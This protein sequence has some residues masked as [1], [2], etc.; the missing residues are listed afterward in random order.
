MYVYYSFSDSFPLYKILSIVPICSLLIS[1]FSVIFTLD[2][3]IGLSPSSLT[4]LLCE[5][6]VKPIYWFGWGGGTVF[7]N[8]RIPHHHFFNKYIYLFIYLWLSW[9]FVAEHRLS[10]VAVSGGYSSLWYAGFSLRWLL[11]LRST[12]SRCTGFSSCSSPAL[13]YRLSSRGAWA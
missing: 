13:E 12:G 1:L 5:P 9:V 4:L 8:S 2:I 10:L 7:F 6:A 11:L 3:S